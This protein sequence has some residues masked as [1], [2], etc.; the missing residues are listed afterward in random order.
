MRLIQHETF[1]SFL[2]NSDFFLKKI[3]EAVIEFDANTMRNHK[4]KLWECVCVG[5]GVCNAEEFFIV[6]V[7][8][9]YYLLEMIVF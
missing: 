9:S 2:R 6:S 1:S 4:L 5:G 7:L 3:F 8:T